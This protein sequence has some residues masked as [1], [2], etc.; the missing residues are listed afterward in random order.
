MA[1]DG[2]PCAEWCFRTHHVLIDDAP[3]F[4]HE[5]KGIGCDRNVVS[6]Q[7]GNWNPYRSGL[8]PG[9]EVPVRTDVF[10]LSMAAESF[11]Y[12][13][14]LEAWTNDFKSEMDNKHAYYAISSFILVKSNN[15]IDAAVVE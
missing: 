2:R 3:L 6:P 13:Y 4:T 12:T 15:P 8:C 11:C 5:L 14:E 9:M 1:N 10:D 7:G